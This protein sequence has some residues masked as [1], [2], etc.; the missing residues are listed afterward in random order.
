LSAA[1]DATFGTIGSAVVHV[2]VGKLADRFGIRPLAIIV[3]LCLAATCVAMAAVPSAWLLL[4]ILFGLRQFGQGALG[5]LAITGVGRWFARRRGAL[6]RGGSA[7]PVFPASRAGARK[8]ARR[9]GRRGWREPATP[10]DAREEVLRLPEFFAVLTGI[11]APS[12]VMSGI[13]FHQ[14]HLVEVSVGHSPGS[15]PGSR[16][17]RG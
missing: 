13:F 15:R 1:V 7:R 6:R 12:F 4:P 8:P 2:W 11:A 16:P 14:V 10:M 9:G 17:M 5:H 3:L